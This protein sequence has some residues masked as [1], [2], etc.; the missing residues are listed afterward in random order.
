V[1][2]ELSL[3]IG[4]AWDDGLCSESGS[5]LEGVRGTSSGATVW[6]SLRCSLGR[7]TPPRSAGLCDDTPPPVT[8]WRSLEGIRRGVRVRSDVFVGTGAP[9]GG[10][11]GVTEK[12]SWLK[13][14]E[15]IEDDL[16]GEWA[17]RVRWTWSARG[18]CLVLSRGDCLLGRG[19][20]DD[21]IWSG[22]V[23]R[24]GCVSES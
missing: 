1:K 23:T 2:P 5:A 16:R 3:T 9:R 20:L 13:A 8:T 7:T 10:E 11:E 4:G 15:E 6:F 22:P 19:E 14:G 12:L 21:E 18:I 17:E 24:P